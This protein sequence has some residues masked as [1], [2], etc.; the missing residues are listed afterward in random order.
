[1]K[2]TWKSDFPFC[3][4]LGSSSVDSSVLTTASSFSSTSVAFEVP[5]IF[6]DPSATS[7]EICSSWTEG[8]FF[9]FFLGA[10]AP[11]I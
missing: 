5:S 6:S 4:S 11:P 3:E 2:K 9:F 1:M 7:S 8:C 10:G